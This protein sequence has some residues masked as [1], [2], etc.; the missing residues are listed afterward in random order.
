MPFDGN[1]MAYTRI[2]FFSDFDGT[3]TGISGRSLTVK[4]DSTTQRLH[5]FY[6]SLFKKQKGDFKYHLWPMLSQDE[7]QKK[8][9]A[10][11]G[12]Y[13]PQNIHFET[14]MGIALIKPDAVQALHHL[15]ANKDVEFNIV[16]KNNPEYVRAL[17][18]YQGFSDEEIAKIKIHP[19]QNK[20]I[21][22]A[23]ELNRHKDKPELELE[24]DVDIY[25]LDDSYDDFSLMISG[26]HNHLQ[27][28]GSD[29][30]Q[31]PVG[32][33]NLEIHGCRSEIGKFDWHA[34][35]E[36]ALALTKLRR[37]PSSCC[38]A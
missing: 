6:K 36:E 32:N 27:K 35:S 28:E 31:F 22:V 25:V 24:H 34:H 12:K 20:K 9:E 16:T 11:F 21:L 8:F 23:N 29:Q 1:T 3:L 7:L 18:K 4:P 26:I 38:S 15:L 5:N 2:I 33:H 10:Q 30:Y 19:K 37:S 17:L 13:N 14:G